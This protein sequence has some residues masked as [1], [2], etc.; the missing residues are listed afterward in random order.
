V[1]F[2]CTAIKLFLNVLFFLALSD[3]ETYINVE[4]IIK[5]VIPRIFLV[6]KLSEKGLAAGPQA[7]SRFSRKILVD[8]FDHI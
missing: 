7:R 1:G 5:I 3:V 4:K 2:L 8:L 6:E